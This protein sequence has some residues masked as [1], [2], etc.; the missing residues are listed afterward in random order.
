MKKLNVLAVAF[1]IFLTITMNV[2]ALEYKI[3]IRQNR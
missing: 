3:I 1:L 2:S